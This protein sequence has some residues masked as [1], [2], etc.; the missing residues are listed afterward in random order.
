VNELPI[1]LWKERLEDKIGD[2]QSI[3]EAL[4]ASDCYK[5]GVSVHLTSRAIENQR[6]GLMN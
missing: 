2:F 5:N 6:K 4:L 3:S 1:K